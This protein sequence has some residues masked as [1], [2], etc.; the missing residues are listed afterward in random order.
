MRLSTVNYFG[1]LGGSGGT[2]L[3]VTPAQHRVADALAGTSTL[4]RYSSLDLRLFYSGNLSTGRALGRAL[5]RRHRRR[6][7]RRAASTSPPQV[8]G[9]PAAAIH[10]VWVTYLAGG[11]WSPLDLAQCVAPLPAACGTVEDSRLWKG[12][13]AA[14]PADLQYVVQAANGLGLVSLDD[15]RGAYHIA[16]GGPPAAAT[17][18]ALVSPPAGGTFGDSPS[19]TA[20]LTSA[21]RRW[22]ARR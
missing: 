8:V 9:D 19:V 22:R 15:N 12:R 11:A 6:S 17:S 4:R 21:G 3:L 2:S 18:L 5:D 7:R 1:A 20:A 10:H 13:L 14:A 16:S